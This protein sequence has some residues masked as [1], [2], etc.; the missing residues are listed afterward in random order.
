MM[1]YFAIV[2]AALLLA[3]CDSGFVPDREHPARAVEDP[4]ARGSANSEVMGG[5]AGAMPLVTVDMPRT[6]EEQPKVRTLVDE[7]A[8]LNPGPTSRPAASQPATKPATKPGEEV[9]PAPAS[10]NFK[11]VAQQRPADLIT[12]TR[13]NQGNADV[14]VLCPGGIGTVTLERTGENWPAVIRVHLRYDVNRAFT[15]LEGFNAYELPGGGAD[16]RVALKTTS[17]KATATAQVAVPGFSR[18]PQ[19]RIEW[20]DAYR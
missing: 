2:A 15:M 12:I 10:E 4:F 16:R 11:V 14:W 13:D 18:S 7:L 6:K 8:G 17:D 3:A 5:P 19:I 20:V 9:P 1:R